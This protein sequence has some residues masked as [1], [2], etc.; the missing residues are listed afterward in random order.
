MQL[1][2]NNLLKI[3]IVLN[4]LHIW[5]IARNIVSIIIIA[6]S[7]YSLI[8]HHTIN[9]PTA[10]LYVLMCVCMG[11]FV[12]VATASAAKGYIPI[13]ALPLI[14]A[15]P[16]VFVFHYRHWQTLKKHLSQLADYQ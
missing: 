7:P 8:N 10:Q 5:Q 9:R 13:F 2:H 6:I 12:A 1:D 3:K 4:L 11:L 14:V 16:T 15:I